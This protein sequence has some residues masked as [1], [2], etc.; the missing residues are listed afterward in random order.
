MHTNGTNCDSDR[1]QHIKARR[2][3]WGGPIR[4]RFFGFCHRYRSGAEF[5]SVLQWMAPCSQVTSRHQASHSSEVPLPSLTG[6]GIA[7]FSKGVGE[8]AGGVEG[9]GIVSLEPKAVLEGGSGE[10]SDA[11][12]ETDA[13]RLVE[14][15]LKELDVA[16]VDRAR[17]RASSLLAYDPAPIA[18]V[19]GGTIVIAGTAGEARTVPLGATADE[20]SGSGLLVPS[21]MPWEGDRSPRCRAGEWIGAVL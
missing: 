7:S 2:G 8:S 18:T 9:I 19:L 20:A 13:L 1:V 5:V 17:R 4:K 12:A 11:A 3:F 15:L 16:A 21:S 14:L 10:L 6:V